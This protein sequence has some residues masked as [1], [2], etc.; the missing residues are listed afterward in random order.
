MGY[1]NLEHHFPNIKLGINNVSS[2]KAI[3]T[4][5]QTM[6]AIKND[7]DSLTYSCIEH[8][9]ILQPAYIAEPTGGVILPIVMVKTKTSPKCT[10]SKPTLVATGR[11]IG[12]S[13]SI[14]TE[15]STNMPAMIRNMTMIE[16]N[17]YGLS[18]LIASNKL[19]ITSGIRSHMSPSINM[20]D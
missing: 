2:G 6:V 11:N 17:I 9:K 16:S 13:I 3:T 14:S 5:R 19:A 1:S 12:V 10:G 7:N 4:A 18:P 15:P 20:D 8:S